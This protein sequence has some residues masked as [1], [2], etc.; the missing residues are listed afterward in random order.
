MEELA[1]LFRSLET[2]T[3]NWSLDTTHKVVNKTGRLAHI[4]PEVRHVTGALWVAFTGVFTSD[5]TGIRDAPLGEAA[6]S[7]FS[8]TVAW[9]LQH[10]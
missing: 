7:R 6:R 5:N 9:L 4:V 1:K 10:I 3:G 2:G 8:M